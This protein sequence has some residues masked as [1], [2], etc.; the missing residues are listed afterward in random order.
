[1]L[2]DEAD[3]M[4]GARSGLYGAIIVA[5]RGAHASSLDGGSTATGAEVNVS[6][7]NGALYRDITVLATDDDEGIGTHQMPYVTA[8]HSPVLLNGRATPV[9]PAATGAQRYVLP[10][11][12]RP[13]VAY[14]GDPTVVHL[15]APASE[16]A[17]AFSIESN[18]W[19]SPTGGR[20]SSELYSGLSVVDMSLAGGAGGAGLLSGDLL[21]GDHREPFRE[22]GLWTIFRV[23]PACAGSASVSRLPGLPRPRQCGGGSPVGTVI[24]L[25]LFAL[26]GLIG[27]R[28][29]RT[30]RSYARRSR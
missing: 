25:A 3:P 15:L 24:V 19:T 17:Q 21:M 29:L 7:P 28:N 23:A 26:V 27:L 30:L 9:A 1:M 10:S 20:V 6:A 8:V 11:G 18:E 12:V 5:P 4:F 22:A 16:Q 13:F 14:A 2:R